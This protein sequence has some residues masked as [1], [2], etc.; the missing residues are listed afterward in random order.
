MSITI[1]KP[2][3]ALLVQHAGVQ[4]AHLDAA[5]RIDEI[6]EL[7]QEAD[8]LEAGLSKIARERLSKIAAL[9]KE[10]KQK[11]DSLAHDMTVMFDNIG[12]HPET[13]Q[14]IPGTRYIAKFSKRYT[15]RKIT[16]MSRVKEFLD[17]QDD[18]LFLNLAKL[19]LKDLDSY[20]TPEERLQVLD[21]ELQDR[22]VKVDPKVV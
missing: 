12:A 19:N 5:F 17:A 18:S 10:V 4:E 3:S 14:T 16:D 8:T 6:G 15:Q 2:E 9:R 21:T 22:K 1:N 11:T 20:L 7:A 13:P